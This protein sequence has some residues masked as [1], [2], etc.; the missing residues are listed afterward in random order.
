MAR[1]SHPKNPQERMLLAKAAQ[2]DQRVID[3][4]ANGG[5]VA[6]KFLPADLRTPKMLLTLLSDP[7]FQ[8]GK[9][10]NLAAQSADEVLVAAK[11]GESIVNR[12]LT[13][14]EKINSSNSSPMPKGTVGVNERG[15]RTSDNVVVRRRQGQSIATASQAGRLRM[16]P[17]FE[18][19]DKTL[20]G[21]GITNPTVRQG[22]IASDLRKK[23]YSQSEIDKALRKL[24]KSELRIKE[25]QVAAAEK[26]AR[27]EA[28]RQKEQAGIQK[29][30]T[31]TARKRFLES[32]RR[33]QLNAAQARYYDDAVKED[34]KRNL[35]NLKQ[36][37]KNKETSA[38]WF[39]KKSK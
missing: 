29:R 36:T 14:K 24:A 7:Q 21:R 13:A 16:L 10:I 19:G 5:K 37:Q 28:A 30:Q 35:K 39:V 32:E 1:G 25:T 15:K 2:L 22:E 12:D 20:G 31:E 27:T 6:G 11:R 38:R 3:Y 34:Q 4:Q 8:P 33:A 17:G 9:L 18:D 23:G 26:V